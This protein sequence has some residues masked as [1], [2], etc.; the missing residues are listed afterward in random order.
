MRTRFTAAQVLHACGLS[1]DY[2]STDTHPIVPRQA[3]VALHAIGREGDR[4]IEGKQIVRYL[5]AG[6]MFAQKFAPAVSSPLRISHRL[7][8]ASVNRITSKA[9]D[10]S[11]HSQSSI[12]AVAIMGM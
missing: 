7:S 4:S 1:L 8:K 11:E 12:S 3:E 6:R 2:L 9:S 5:D 10:G